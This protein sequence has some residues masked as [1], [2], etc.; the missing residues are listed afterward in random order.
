MF[1]G[2]GRAMLRRLRE[3][4]RRRAVAREFNRLMGGYD[5]AIDRARE[6]HLPVRALVQAKQEAV[7]RALAGAII[8]GG[9]QRHA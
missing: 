5:Q 7:H 1:T 3:H 9:A 4:L 8:P 2:E 6:R